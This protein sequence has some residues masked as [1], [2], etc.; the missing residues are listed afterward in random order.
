MNMHAVGLQL[1]ATETHLFLTTGDLLQE[2]SRAQD[3]ASFWGKLWR[4]PLDKEPLE[5]SDWVAVS[6]GH[7]NAQG[8][9]PGDAAHV[10]PEFLVSTEH[11]PAGGDEINVI[12]LSNVGALPVPNYG[13]PLR[14][15]G[16]HYNGRIIPDTHAPEFIEPVAFFPYNMVGSHGIS[17]C[18]S[19]PGFYLA[20]SLNGH[21]LYTLILDE[22]RKVSH[23]H[24]EEMGVRL[25]SIT[26]LDNCHILI[27][28][29]IT[30]T[31]AANTNAGPLIRKN[32]CGRGRFYGDPS[33]M[34]TT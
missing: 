20:A 34:V 32:V 3:D 1:L 6:K 25:R 21:K 30:N 16:D 13:W 9:C 14:S 24:A 31:N 15:W 4:A 8:L 12:P 33:F 18:L 26:P 17:E 22:H 27:L 7:R 2:P 5:R 23:L 28:T 10:Q 29:E 19:F 11:G